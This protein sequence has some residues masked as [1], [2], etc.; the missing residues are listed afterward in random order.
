MRFASGN[1]LS[2]PLLFLIPF[3]LGTVHAKT[4]LLDAKPAAIF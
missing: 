2:L 3:V 1:K 4:V